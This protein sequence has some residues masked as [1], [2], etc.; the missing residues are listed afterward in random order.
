MLKPDAGR[1]VVA[2]DGRDHAY[3]PTRRRLRALGV[4]APAVAVGAFGVTDLVLEGTTWWESPAFLPWR[5]LIML[6]MTAATVIFALL[7]FRLI[8]RSERVVRRQNRD[9]G[10][11]AAVASAIQGLDSRLGVARAAVAALQTDSG[12]ERVRIVFEDP[13]DHPVEAIA[14]RTTRPVDAAPDLTEKL[15]CGD[16]PQGELQLWYPRSTAADGISAPILHTMTTQIAYALRLGQAHDDLRRGRNEGHAFYDVL[17][18]ISNLSGTLPT[19]KSIANQIK[20]LLDADA[21]AIVVSLDT[22]NSVRF[23]SDDSVEG[24]SDGTSVLGIGLPDHYDPDTGERVNPIHCSHWGSE[25][26]MPIQGSNGQLGSVWAGRRSDRAFSAR[27]Q[28]FLS[29]M[30]GLADVALAGAL[31][32]EENRLNAVLAE[33]TRIARETHD[34]HAQVLGAVHLRLRGLETAPSV[35]ANPSLVAEVTALADICAEAYADVREVILGLRDAEKQDQG[36]AATLGGYVAKY[37]AHYGIDARFENGVGDRLALSPR[38]EVEIIRVVQ[39]A[40]T[41]VRKHANATKVTVSVDSDGASTTFT[42]TDDGA[43]FATPA[44]GPL[45]GYGVVTMRE[46]LLALGGTLTILSEPQRGTR[47]IATVPEPPTAASRDRK[48]T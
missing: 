7:M 48:A 34:S 16:R 27:D 6:A 17:L 40:L 8:D 45:E 31:L 11:A 33:R 32:R 2:G 12:A 39:E 46:R 18:Q 4:V 38:A 20:R 5:V 47:V 24:C 22:A 3:R 35:V 30:A 13:A 29:T 41:N 26:L 37:E 28:A 10:V 1:R 19:L 44:A 43:G 21:A 15:S 25:A 14:A 42:V 9:L 23:D 36:L